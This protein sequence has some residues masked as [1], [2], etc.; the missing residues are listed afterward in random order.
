MTADLLKKPAM[1]RRFLPALCASALFLSVFALY[2]YA[3][4]SDG[5]WGDG[6]DFV[7]CSYFLGVPH[8]TGYPLFAI[9]GKAAT[10]VPVGTI[11]FRVG[12]LSTCAGALAS[13]VLFLLFYKFIRSLIVSL[14]A[15]YAF[16]AI[17][18]VL[19][20]TVTVEAYALNFLFMTILAFLFIQNQNARVAFGFFL[21]AA[22][23]LGNHGTLIFAAVIL[24]L[25][26]FIQLLKSRAGSASLFVIAFIIFTGFFLYGS[27]PLFA[28]RD[29]QFIWNNPQNLKNFQLL[30]SGADFWSGMMRFDIFKESLRTHILSVQFSLYHIPRRK[31]N[32]SF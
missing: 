23:G 4:E 20:Q 29:S 8:P 26:P 30:L 18:L 32:H 6:P 31:K 11:A 9:L 22:I 21:V 16:C 14:I 19:S 28:A 5:G 1:P 12:L 15:A 3:H 24:G 13:V 2:L 27:L 7:V 25:V 17:S 10:F